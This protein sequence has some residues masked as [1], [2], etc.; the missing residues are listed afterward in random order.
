V[1]NKEKDRTYGTADDKY[2][3]LAVRQYHPSAH[4]VELDHSIMYEIDGFI[5]EMDH[6]VADPAFFL[7]WWLSKHTAGITRVVLS[8]TGADELFAGYHRHSAYQKYLRHYNMLN[9]LSPAFKSVLDHVP[10]GYGFFGRKKIVLYKKLFSKLASD[11]WLTYDNFLSL[12][13]LHPQLIS[14]KWDRYHMELALERDRREYLPEDLLVVGDRA[15]MMNSIEM[16]MPYLDERFSRYVRGIPPGRLMKKGKKWI[17]KMVLEKNGGREYARRS[18]EGFGFPFGRWIRNPE[19]G[20]FLN[21]VTGKENLLFQY[22]DQARIADLIKKHMAGMEDNAQ[23]IWSVFLL[24]A[25]I[26]KKFN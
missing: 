10:S 11:P 4:I 14:G 16:R 22:L 1:V 19:Y 8:G 3:N 15:C 25:W 9:I 20:D 18:K 12:D 5:D 24:D 7:T 17:L 26:R 6:P 13:K 23:E 2:V 21:G